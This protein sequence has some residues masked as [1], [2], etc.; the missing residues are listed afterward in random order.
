MIT[1]FIIGCEIGF[2]VFV[3]AGLLFRYVFKL[4]KVGA[5][6]LICT[7]L[8]DLALVIAAVTDL[9]DGAVA[10]VMHGVAA[11]YIGVSIAFGHRMIRW[12]DERFAHRF[13]GG[14]APVGKPKYGREHAAYERNAWLHHLLAWAIGSAILYGMILFVDDADRTEALLG[15]LRTWSIVLAVD[16]IISFNYTVSPRKEK[17][18]AQ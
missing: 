17:T 1:A 18:K 16:F 5:F 10:T 8:I 3:L 12:A 4:P 15:T 9:R 11:I 13:A 14:P 6:L 7:P 2:W